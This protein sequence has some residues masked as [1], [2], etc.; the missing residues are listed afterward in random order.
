MKPGNSKILFPLRLKVAV[1]FS[2]IL[3]LLSC[4]VALSLVR[5]EWIFLTREGEKRV[6]SLAENLAVNATDPLLSSDDLRLG[7]VTESTMLDGDVR[8]AY[9]V[10]HQGKIVY[11]SNPEKT[12]EMLDKGRVPLS[13]TD[14]IQAVVPIEVEGVKVGT[15]VVGLGA[16]H[17][18]EALRETL[19]GLLIPLLLVTTGGIVGVFFLSGFHIKKIEKLESAVR[20]V[21]SGDFLVQVDVSGRDEVGRLTK[22]FNDM[23]RQI[24]DARSKIEKNFR[25]T[26]RS[27]AAAVEAKDAYTRGHCERVARISRAIAE[28]MGVEKDTLNDLELAAILHDV[29]KIGVNGDILGKEGPLESSEIN[30]MKRHP[31]IGAKILNPISSLEKVG[32]YVKYHHENYNGTGYPEGLSKEEIPLPSRIINLVDAFDAMTS[33][34]SYRPALSHREATERIKKGS[35]SQFD[36]EVVRIFLDLD[37][38]G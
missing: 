27:L 23:V 28:R 9:L 21:G 5:Y 34:R 1:S 25:E 31:A 17:I 26:I 11:H 22:H 33:D 13:D 38:K 16:D 12:G 18:A 3:I 35:G 15:A 37:R 6:K 10:D 20:A 8:Y 36:P 19:K 32:L 4:V 14:V 7:P 30:N 29:G 24:E 2:L